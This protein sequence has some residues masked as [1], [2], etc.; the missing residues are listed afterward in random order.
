[1]RKHISLLSLFLVVAGCQP[2]THPDRL[3]D[4]V[5]NNICHFNFDCCTP[6]E[7]TSSGLFFGGGASNKAACIEE[8]ND[9]LGGV[10]DTAS[11][12]VAAGTAVYDAEGAERCSIQAAID[13]CDAQTVLGVSSDK[14]VFQALYGIDATDPTCVDLASRAFTKGTVKDGGAC[15]SVFDCVEGI[16]DIE[17]EEEG[18]TA[19]GKCVA[20]LKEGDDCS[21]RSCG[22]GLTCD[23]TDTCIKVVLLDDGASCEFDGQC[24]S[25]ACVGEGSCSNGVGSCFSADDCSDFDFCDVD[26]CFDTGAACTEDAD[27]NTATCDNGP[28]CA[29][30]AKITV[31]ICDGL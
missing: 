19:Q 18:T 7:R 23:D 9:T 15:T 26:V 20:P 24:T 28:V 25:G 10:F 14:R 17:A 1:M 3:G 13:S 22:Q 30:A 27:C 5:F 31:E 16:C 11:A 4:T 6:I 8:L 29:A 12:A 2:A 21:E